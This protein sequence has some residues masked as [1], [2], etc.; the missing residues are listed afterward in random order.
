MR[1]LIGN[2][3]SAAK[4]DPAFFT[5]VVA[6]PKSHGHAVW[7]VGF[8]AVFT[9]FGTV[10]RAGAT[11]VNIFTI[12]TLIAWY[13]WAFTVFYAG[14][15]FLRVPDH[16][17][18]RKAVMRVMAFACAPGIMRIAGLII[19]VSWGLFFGTAIW[20]ILASVVGMKQAL[21]Y[22][23]T[24]RVALLCGVSWVAA[25]FFQGILIVAMFS[26]FQISSPLH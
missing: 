17:V 1:K 7:V 21:H 3:V 5:G 19:P 24:A 15:R 8:F 23:G 14:S 6:D 12:T 9:G 10:P 25:A 26:A 16:S 2:M 20:T 22:P 4:L 13:V 11:A 18:D